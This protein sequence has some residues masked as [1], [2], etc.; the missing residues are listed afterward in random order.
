MAFLGAE[1]KQMGGCNAASERQTGKTGPYGQD[2]ATVYSLADR[3]R[4]TQV[5]FGEKKKKGS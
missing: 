5:R 1:A 3:Y 2:F 4:E